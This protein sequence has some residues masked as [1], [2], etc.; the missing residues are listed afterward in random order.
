M[1]TAHIFF[2]HS[3][4]ILSNIFIFYLSIYILLKDKGQRTKRQKYKKGTNYCDVR[5]DHTLAMFYLYSSLAG[6]FLIVCLCKNMPDALSGREKN[7]I[8]LL[9][10]LKGLFW[11]T[12]RH[13]HVYFWSRVAKL[14]RKRNGIFTWKQ[15]NIWSIS[16]SQI[17]TAEGH[18]RKKRNKRQIKG[19][20]HVL[21]SEKGFH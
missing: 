11:H 18:Q 20:L 14:R 10:N 19:I 3:Y 15:F 13:E 21:S 5:A 8:L 1:H 7:L 4:F 2:I 16:K 9:Q 12:Y 17:C 6:W